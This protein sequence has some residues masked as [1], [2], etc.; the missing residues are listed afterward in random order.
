[1]AYFSPYKAIEDYADPQ[2]DIWLYSS[3]ASPLPK[4]QSYTGPN[5]YF[6]YLQ[7][8]KQKGEHGV[9]FGYKTI[10]SDALGWIISRV[11][12]KDFTQLVSERIWQPL[13]TE[14]DAYVTV[15][16]KGT[17]FAGGGL[18]AGLRDLGRFGQ[19]L[20]DNGKINDRLLF[21]SEAVKSIRAGGDKD[22][23]KKAGYSTLTG[24]SYR[25]MWWVFHNK[26]GA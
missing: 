8:A 3:A 7:T 2:A 26:H 25:G 19:V 1:M 18:S 23:F 11:T 15:D 4:L 24:G 12:G 22:A 20:L 5:G 13:G 9:A 21:P 14:Q 16:A 17:P 6:K 10:N